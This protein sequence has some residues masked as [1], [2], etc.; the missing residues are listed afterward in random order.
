LKPYD[1]FDAEAD[2]QALNKAM[3]GLGTDEESITKIL[4][5]RASWQ[6][7]EIVET[8]KTLF[9]ED[10]IEQLD[11]EL[12]HNYQIVCTALCMTPADFD[13]QCLN[14]AIKGAGT[15]EGCLVEILCTRTNEQIEAIKEAYKT[16]YEV[17]LE[18][19]IVGD[20]SG[21]FRRFMVSL[22]Q[23][24]RDEGDD[25][26]QDKVEEDAKELHEAGEGQWGTD[27][28]VFNMILA[29]RSFPHLQAVFSAYKDLSE[30]DIEEALESELSADLLDGMKTV[31]RCVK[32]RPTA[33][34]YELHK[35][36]KGAG[37]DDDPLIRV[38]VARAEVDM[39]QIKY[40]FQRDYEESLADFIAGDCSGD[41]E[42]IILQLIGEPKDD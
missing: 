23:A 10:L 6:R 9:G 31:V 5:N 20:T 28:S 38:V 27:E 18:D 13:A 29:A 17:P 16:K 15:D 34:A 4:G 40:A 36:M 41:Y 12:D 3:K 7:M 37:T 22:L 8:F 39:V 33:F 1:D 21:D 26:D 19:D 25:V 30:K 24:N 14:Q 35:S 32:D 42:E 2:A 11:S